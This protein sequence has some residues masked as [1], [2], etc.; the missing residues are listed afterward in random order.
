M[1]LSELPQ[2]IS[3]SGVSKQYG[4]PKK[5]LYE[6]TKNDQIPYYKIG[7]R[8]IRFD[9]KEVERMIQNQSSLKKGKAYECH[10]L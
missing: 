2:L 8:M 4:I 7:P 5:V 10:I 6:W 1:K 9:V 3:V